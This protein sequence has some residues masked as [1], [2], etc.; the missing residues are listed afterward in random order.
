M[1]IDR[2]VIV[3]HCSLLFTAAAAAAIPSSILASGPN[4]DV[5]K[6]LLL[7]IL[8]LGATLAQSL[9][10]D[11]L[12]NLNCNVLLLL[13]LLFVVSQEPHFSPLLP[14]IAVLGQEPNSLITSNWTPLS[15]MRERDKGLQCVCICD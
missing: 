8:H 2:L 9:E 6:L 3:I 7:L 5:L 4:C 12:Q 10:K 15:F 13:F 11:S 14:F 1:L